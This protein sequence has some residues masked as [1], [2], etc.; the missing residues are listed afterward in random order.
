MLEMGRSKRSD[1]CFFV[2]GR[3]LS[4]RLTRTSARFH[5]VVP[6]ASSTAWMLNT[7][8]S[9]LRV[10]KRACALRNKARSVS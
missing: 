10:D 1:F 2:I 3:P 7:F 8:V 6:A 5:W 4:P 9:V